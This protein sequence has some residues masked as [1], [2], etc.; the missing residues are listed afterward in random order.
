MNLYKGLIGE[1][2]V[3]ISGVSCILTSNSFYTGDRY[4]LD[5]IFTTNNT[6]KEVFFEEFNA[7]F[8]RFSERMDFDK[9]H[10]HKIAVKLCNM[11][12][13]TN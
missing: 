11:E 4:S 2:V 5:R 12:K 1:S 6:T 8:K 7:T 10:F 13:N 3:T 9:Q